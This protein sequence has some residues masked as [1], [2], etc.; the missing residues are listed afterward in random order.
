MVVDPMPAMMKGKQREQPVVAPTPLTEPEAVLQKSKE[1]VSALKE[2]PRF[3][4]VNPKS[5][6]EKM[7]N[8]LPQYR[9]VTELMNETNQEKCFQ[10]LP[11]QPVM[12]KLGQVLGTSYDLGQC[13]Q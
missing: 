12:L 3:E 6:N 7:R 5:S 10:M 4:V 11:E 1:C 13:F 9:Y 2:T 8:Q